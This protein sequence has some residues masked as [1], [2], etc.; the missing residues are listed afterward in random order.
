MVL[1][2]PLLPSG[3]VSVLFVKSIKSRRVSRGLLT[4]DKGQTAAFDRDCGASGSPVP[5]GSEAASVPP[6]YGLRF[7]HGDR[8]QNWEKAVQPDQDQP[9]EVA[10][11]NSRWALSA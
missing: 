11:P 2:A 4:Y 8:I 10:E 6:D 3:H 7:D 9:V 1:A 5:V